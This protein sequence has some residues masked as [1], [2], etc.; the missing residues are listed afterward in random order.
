MKAQKRDR[1]W[2]SKVFVFAALLTTMGGGTARAQEIVVGAQTGGLGTVDYP[3]SE[4]ST[5]AFGPFVKVNPYGWAAFKLDATFGHFDGGSYFSSSPAV[6]LNPIAYEEFS[7]GFIGGAGFYKLPSRSLRFGLNGGVSGDFAL[8]NHLSVGME[9]RY[10][11]VFDS[12][13]I[14]NVFLTLGYSFE[15]GGDW[16]W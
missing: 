1:G 4:K 3:G 6:Q 13:N 16:D 12:P 5:I 9:A 11:T 10:H 8:T 7:L 15:T 14:W 2:F